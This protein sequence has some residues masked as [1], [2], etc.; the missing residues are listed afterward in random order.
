MAI[1]LKDPAVDQLAR[2][3]ARLE[4]TSITEAIGAALAERHAKLLAAREER[5]RRID[6]CLARIRALPVLDPRHP[7]EMLYDEDGQLR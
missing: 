2:E 7:D 4:G 6:E 5:L 1:Y 3:V